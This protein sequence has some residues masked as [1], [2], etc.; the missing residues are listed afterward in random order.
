MMQSSEASTWG[1]VARSSTST[2]AMRARRSG[3]GSSSV[4]RKSKDGPLRE[5]TPHS[6]SPAAT[7]VNW[8][9]CSEM[10]VP[11]STSRACIFWP[12]M[13]SSASSMIRLWERRGRIGRSGVDGRRAGVR[14]TADGGVR[15]DD[16]DLA[17][18]VGAVVA[19]LDLD[20]EPSAH[21]AEAV[22]SGP[23]AHLRGRGLLDRERRLIALDRG[24]RRRDLRNLQQAP[25]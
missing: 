13:R 18:D 5:S 19:D 4:G 22:E 10:T 7:R 25:E 6:R 16:L 8:T 17:V 11:P 9:S 3:G 20:G 15:D 1:R 12:V 14:P 24:R 21:L 2:W 23:D